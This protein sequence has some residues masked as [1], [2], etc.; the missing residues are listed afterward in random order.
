VTFFIG[1]ALR[2]L[3]RSA[4]PS[5]AAI[6]TVVLTTLLLGVF[7]PVIKASSTTNENVREQLALRV[8]L[9]KNATKHEAI[10]AK[11]KIARIPHVERTQYISKGEGLNVLR[12]EIGNGPLSRGLGQLRGN[13][14]P[15]SINVYP[16]DP[17]NLD[18]IQRKILRRGAK[19]GPK[20]IDPAIDSISQS[21]QLAHKIHEVTNAVKIVLS[22]ISV[23]LLVASLML[24]ANTIRLSIYARRREIEVM[25]LVGATNWFIRWPFVLEGLIVGISGA[26]IAVGLLW[27]GKVT[28]VD[29]LAENLSLID[30]FSTIRFAPLIILLIAAAVV[31]STLGSGVT[32]RRFLRV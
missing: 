27:I 13:P 8:F 11:K 24:V 2:A 4:A 5:L 6:V 9:K 3:R 22:V 18:S 26:A 19:G 31:V 21:Q 7:V 16:D 15:A 17:G 1:E 14:L 23:L 25:K 28:I 32:L 29:P 12:G 30:N 20:P 10:A